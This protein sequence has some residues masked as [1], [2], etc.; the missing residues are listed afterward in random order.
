MSVQ[1]TRKMLGCE[2]SSLNDREIQEMINS[3][4]SFCEVVV[5]NLP[6][7]K[8]FQKLLLIIKNVKLK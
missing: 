2:V 4:V 3:A 7:N 5:D 8:N 1:Q 6:R